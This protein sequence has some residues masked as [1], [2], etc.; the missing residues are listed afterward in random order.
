MRVIIVHDYLTQRGGAERVALEMARTFP[1]SVILTSVYSPEQ[2]YPEFQELE[3]DTFWLQRSPLLK[4]D[5]RLALPVLADA[6][7]RRHVYA[8]LILCSSSGFAHMVGTRAPKIVYCHNPPR[9]LYQWNEYKM[10]LGPAARSLVSLMRPHLSRIDREAARNSRCYLANSRNVASR[11]KA[12]YGF[13]APV[14]HPPRGLDPDGPREPIPGLP[15]RFLLTVGRPRGYKRTELLAEAVAGMPDLHLV[16]VGGTLSR[17]K[18]PNIHQLSG[19]TD[20][21][22]RWLYGSAEGLLACSFE[23]FGLTPVEAFAFGTPVAATP[24]GG[25]L[26]TCVDGLTGSWLDGTSPDALRAS[27]RKFIEMDWDAEAISKHGEQWAP[28]LFRQELRSMVDRML[29]PAA[30]RG[31]GPVEALGSR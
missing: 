10:G 16:T 24:E 17:G 1:G 5:P 2:T 29:S 27:I 18:S 19:V 15:D 14:L 11:I 22:L 25:Y 28:Y 7:K 30:G 13:D 3:V 26:E 23:D 9:W 20:P 6:F 12:A 4:R 21:Q 8:D 31:C